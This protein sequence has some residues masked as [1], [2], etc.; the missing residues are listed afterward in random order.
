MKP[1]PE[2]LHLGGLKTPTLWVVPQD[3]LS[4]WVTTKRRGFKD[5]VSQCDFKFAEQLERIRISYLV[6]F[7]RIFTNILKATVMYLP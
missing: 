5:I 6:T 7:T 4:Q 3:G 1:L 2:S